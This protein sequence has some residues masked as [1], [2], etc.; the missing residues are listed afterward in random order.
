RHVACKMCS[1]VDSIQ[2]AEYGEH[3]EPMSPG[4]IEPPEAH[5]QG[6]GAGRMRR[7]KRMVR[8][9]QRPV[10]VEMALEPQRAPQRADECR[11]A[12][13]RFQKRPRPQPP[14][15][16]LDQIARQTRG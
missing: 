4:W 2:G 10:P 8:G 13:G 6:N 7:R 5:G 14:E 3:T 15:L 16:K 11:A 12:G 1:A 9:L